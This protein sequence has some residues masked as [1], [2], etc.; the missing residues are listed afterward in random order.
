M[1]A[2]IITGVLAF[3]LVLF[4]DWGSLQYQYQMR[5]FDR[6]KITASIVKAIDAR[7]SAALKDLMCLNI[8][9]NVED[10]SGKIDE[11][12]STINGKVTK[13]RVES[14]GQ[15]SSARDGKR[16]NQ[17]GW[18]IYFS[19]ATNN[20]RMHILWEVANNFAPDETGI[21]RILLLEGAPPHTELKSIWATEGVFGWHD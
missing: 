18:D 15:Y 2:K 8:K 19:T 5:I 16:V 14:A 7:D 13:Y 12:I 3:L 10:L 9:E 1:F 6:D 20:F 4:P 17:I 11:V 21:R